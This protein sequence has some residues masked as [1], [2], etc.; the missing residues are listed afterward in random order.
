[1]KD[2]SKRNAASRPSLLFL[3]RV[4]ACDDETGGALVVAR[5]LALGRETPGRNRVAAARS[6]AFAA[7]ERM[8]DRVHG[9]AAVVRLAS[10]PALAAG[11]A[12]RD[13]H[14]VRVRDCTDG[15]HAAPVHQSLLPGIEPQDDVFL[16]TADDLG[17]GTGRARE[18][19]ALADLD[20]DVVHD[21]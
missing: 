16:I 10:H 8:I 19:A 4:A 17:V 12:D 6:T 20:L 3:P 14:V 11:L 7:A 1:R 18:L 21:S 5:L 13:V 9:D 15:R 2:L